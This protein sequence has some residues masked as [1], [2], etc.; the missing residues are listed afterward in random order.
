MSGLSTHVLDTARGVPA[1]GILLT[2]ERQESSGQWRT[3]ASSRT[4]SDGRCRQL[5]PQ[6]EILL[7]GTYRLAFE[8]GSYYQAQGIKTLYPNVLVIFCVQDGEADFHMPLLL[9]P[10]G[11]TTYRGS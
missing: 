11:Y 10:Y 3:L 6:G 7:P 9:S 5:L 8:T 1:G 4:E 2:L